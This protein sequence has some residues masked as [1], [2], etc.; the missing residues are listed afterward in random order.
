MKGLLTKKSTS[1]AW[2]LSLAS[3]MFRTPN[4]PDLGQ[5]RGSQTL[6]EPNPR[7]GSGFGFLGENPN[8]T[9]HRQHCDKLCLRSDK[10]KAAADSSYYPKVLDSASKSNLFSIVIGSIWNI[11]AMGRQ[12]CRRASIAEDESPFRLIDGRTSV[13]TIAVRGCLYAAN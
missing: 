3:N 10:W 4:E 6:P 2:E 1:S 7:S 8:L 13:I 9:G 12:P 11:S 5:V